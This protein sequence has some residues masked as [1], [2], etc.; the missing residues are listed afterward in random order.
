M[1]T[2]NEVVRGFYRGRQRSLMFAFLA[3]TRLFR[4]EVVLRTLL[5]VAMGGRKARLRRGRFLPWTVVQNIANAL[6]EQ[7]AGLSFGQH[8]R[9]SPG[10][11]PCLSV[12]P[13]VRLEGVLPHSDPLF[14]FPIRFPALPAFRFQTA[15][16]R[17]ISFA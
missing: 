17:R 7:R 8:G 14:R 12:P 10:G 1:S 13:K 9:V 4:S 2:G 16:L 6:D 5:V 15:P 11:L 3:Y